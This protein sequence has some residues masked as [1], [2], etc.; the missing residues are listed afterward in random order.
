MN[1]MRKVLNRI[2]PDWGILKQ[3][4]IDLLPIWSVTVFPIFIFLIILHFTGPIGSP[5]AVY[6]A[7]LP[8]LFNKK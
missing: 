6:K 7:A 5:T 8:E 4:M 2:T 3:C 1:T